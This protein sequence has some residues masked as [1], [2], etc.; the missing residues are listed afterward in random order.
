LLRVWAIPRWRGPRE[1]AKLFLRAGFHHLP[2]GS[3][4]MFRLEE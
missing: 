4:S 3:P 2:S 1:L